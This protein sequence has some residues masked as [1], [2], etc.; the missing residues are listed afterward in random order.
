MARKWSTEFI[1][2]V[3]LLLQVRL[4]FSIPKPDCE[5]LIGHTLVTRSRESQKEQADSLWT[6]K[7][8]IEREGDS[9]KPGAKSLLSHIDH[10]L[11]WF[12]HLLDERPS[13]VIELDPLK[14]ENAAAATGHLLSTFVS[15]EDRRFRK[16][17]LSFT[18]TLPPKLAIDALWGTA[19]GVG[20]LSRKEV[21]KANEKIIAVQ[22]NNQESLPQ[23]YIS[24]EI[25]HRLKKTGI[26]ISNRFNSRL[27]G[28]EP[29]GEGKGL[30][31][32]FIVRFENG[33][34]AIFKP[35]WGEHSYSKDSANLNRIGFS[36]ESQA[37]LFYE[38][39]FKRDGIHLPFIVEA[40]LH[41]NGR[42]FGVGSLQEF[43]EGYQT[44]AEKYKPKGYQ[45]S[46]KNLEPVWS[47]QRR[48][49]RWRSLAPWIQTF[50]YLIGNVDRFPH[51]RA[52]TGNPNNL[53]VRETRTGGLEVALIDNA[54]GRG[55]P[56]PL[57][58]LPPAHTIP[59]ELRKVIK[60][61]DNTKMD[62]IRRDFAFQIPHNAIE[63][64][65]QRIRRVQNYLKEA[66][67]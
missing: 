12:S 16:R 4:S 23:I 57:E 62:E 51:G 1:I 28:V 54:K 18:L 26:D 43:E 65:I 39:Y 11:D 29:M 10:K 3:I 60:T 67:L 41:F 56:T 31:E 63:D 53:L 32:S 27:I 66:G 40:T 19:R 58:Y 21:R 13:G 2:T 9:K 50:D 42:H 55:Y 37:Y 49:D 8:F 47:S 20:A 38:K 64:V 45:F 15:E 5:S 59:L 30:S 61:F 24:A 35:L 52:P 7:K 46:W 17:L 34:R 36:R 14:S 44:L 25:Q 22:M 6:L 33:K 48:D